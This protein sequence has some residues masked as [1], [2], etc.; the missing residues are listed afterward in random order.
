MAPKH[1]IHLVLSIKHGNEDGTESPWHEADLD[2]YSSNPAN[3]LPAVSWD[4]YEYAPAH[5]EFEFVFDD[6]TLEMALSY[7]TGSI[8]ETTVWVGPGRYED[9]GF[10]LDV[11]Q[12]TASGFRG[13]GAQD[14]ARRMGFT[15]LETAVNETS[16]ARA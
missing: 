16:E 6:T 1:P 7:L 5:E 8:E 11:Q 13:H 15:V 3:G 4:V 10:L 2:H 14:A 12:L 9:C